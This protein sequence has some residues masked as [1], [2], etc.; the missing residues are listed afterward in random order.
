VTDV[1]APSF[2]AGPTLGLRAGTV[3]DTGT[4][5][6]VTWRA[7]DNSR[8]LRVT[9]T[10]PARAT[11]APTTRTWNTV[12]GP[13]LRTYSLTAVDGAGNVRT[14]AISG[15]TVA[16]SETVATPQGRWTAVRSGS[17]LN[18]AALSATAKNASLAWTFSGPSVAWVATRTQWS[19]QAVVYLDGA[20]VATVDLRA[21]YTS[22]RQAVWV[23]NGLSSGRHTVRV[24][25]VGT[26]GRPTVI[27][28]GIVSLS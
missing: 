23:R 10:A 16:R 6:A 4:P 7:T 26:S 24:V 9:A 13:G 22:Y 3:N 19:G 14:A 18:G 17:Y 25:V 21:G 8:L 27:S 2:A 1:T 28:D 15:G 20:K 5:V 12:A 11:F